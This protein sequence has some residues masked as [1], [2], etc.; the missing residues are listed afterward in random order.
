MLVKRVF[1]KMI[2]ILTAEKVF[3]ESSKKFPILKT[4]GSVALTIT[5]NRASLVSLVT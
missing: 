4:I 5:I 3:I 1:K 2:G